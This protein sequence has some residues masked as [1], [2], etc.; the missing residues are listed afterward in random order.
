ML[1]SLGK[2][3]CDAN[4]KSLDKKFNGFIKDIRISFNAKKLKKIIKKV[5]KGEK[6]TKAENNKIKNENK[7]LL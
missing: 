3:K 5:K 4:K 6:L 1:K 7:C 2:D